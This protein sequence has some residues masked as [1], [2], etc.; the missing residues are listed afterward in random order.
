M[1]G[2]FL[3]YVC[4]FPLAGFALTRP[5]PGSTHKLALCGVEGDA[6]LVQIV[7]REAGRAAAADTRPNNLR[8]IRKLRIEESAYTVRF[9]RFANSIECVLLTLLDLF[10][11]LIL[12]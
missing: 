4:G 5:R 9:A 11:Y 1:Q 2:S 8:M 12:D 7:E 6:G 10:R 3:S